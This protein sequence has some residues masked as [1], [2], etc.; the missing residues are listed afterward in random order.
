MSRSHHIHFGMVVRPVQCSV[1]CID[2][3]K[4]TVALKHDLVAGA[5][6]EVPSDDDPLPHLLGEVEQPMLLLTIQLFLSANRQAT[7]CQHRT[8][9]EKFIRYPSV[10]SS[11]LFPTNRQLSQNGTLSEPE[12]TGASKHR[13]TEVSILLVVRNLC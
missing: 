6:R 3:K 11:S 13:N 12:N 5:V 8:K 7:L 1:V 4:E 2:A 9:N 10:R